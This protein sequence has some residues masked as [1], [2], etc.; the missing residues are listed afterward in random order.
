MNKVGD[1]ACSRMGDR[2]C[3]SV[4]KIYTKKSP[5]HPLHYITTG[6]RHIRHTAHSI[7]SIPL[8]TPSRPQPIAP[9]V[10][11]AAIPADAADEAAARGSAGVRVSARLRLGSKTASSQDAGATLCITG[12]SLM[13]LSGG[14]GSGDRGGRPQLTMLSF[15]LSGSR[16]RAS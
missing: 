2:T 10:R 14:P 12:L 15:R 1:S 13:G 9:R 8:P 5:L 16:A 4:K 3:P 7:P 11:V 6:H